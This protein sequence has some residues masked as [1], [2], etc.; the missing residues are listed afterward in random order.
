M[1]IGIDIAKRTPRRSHVGWVKYPYPAASAISAKSERSPLHGSATS[2]PNEPDA[3]DI[4]V[5]CR[6]TSAPTPLSTPYATETAN[7]RRWIVTRSRN[8]CSGRQ[9]RRKSIG[10]S[11]RRAVRRPKKASVSDSKS[12]TNPTISRRIWLPPAPR[13]PRNSEGTASTSPQTEG[14]PT[15]SASSRLSR[16]NT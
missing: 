15:D 8:E 3:E 2:I 13:K 11:A 5:P 16:H 12:P 4:I 6:T 9:N 10:K 14:S 7:I 1:A